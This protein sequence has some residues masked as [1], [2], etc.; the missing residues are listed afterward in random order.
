MDRE[1]NQLDALVEAVL[2]SPKYRH[3]CKELI[4]HIG[5]QELHKRRKL[6]EAVK[7]T[8]NKLHQIGGAY[9]DTRGNYALWLNELKKAA[10]SGN[11]DNLLQVCAKIMTYHASTRER[12]PILDQF[13]TQIFTHLPPIRTVLDIACG[14]NPLAIPWIPL[15][16]NAEYYAYD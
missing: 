9:L 6:K 5:T 8:K 13:Y 3:I 10:Q 1:N 11:R 4:L 7:E 15:A 2:A 14:L 16:E 12:L